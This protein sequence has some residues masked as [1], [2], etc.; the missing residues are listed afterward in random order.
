MENKEMGLVRDNRKNNQKY[1]NLVFC[2]S[3]R[4]REELILLVLKK[5]KSLIFG[6]PTSLKLGERER[7]TES[8]R[9]KRALE[10]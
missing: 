10:K 3:T 5:K 2:I 9:K 6:E 8:R 7:E 1:R 4:N